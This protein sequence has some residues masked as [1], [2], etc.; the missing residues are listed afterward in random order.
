[1]KTND[2]KDWGVFAR[3][4][5]SLLSATGAGLLLTILSFYIALWLI[6]AEEHFENGR[7]VQATMPVGHIIVAIITGIAAGLTVLILMTRTFV[8]RTGTITD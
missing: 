1:M 8:L 7:L 5:I 6:P 2:E 4:G 3:L